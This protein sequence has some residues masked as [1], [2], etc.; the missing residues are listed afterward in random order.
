LN[1]CD[2]SSF[3]QLMATFSL[4][5]VVIKPFQPNS[6]IKFCCDWGKDSVMD[7]IRHYNVMAEVDQEN[8]EL[9]KDIVPKGARAYPNLDEDALKE[10]CDEYSTQMIKF[11]SVS[12]SGLCIFTLLFCLVALVVSPFLVHS[13]MLSVLFFIYSILALLWLVSFRKFCMI[14][15]DGGK[16]WLMSRKRINRKQDFRH[17][18]IPFIH[19]LYLMLLAF[20]LTIILNLGLTDSLIQALASSILTIAL[21]NASWCFIQ[22]MYVAVFRIPR[23]F[24]TM[25]PC[26]MDKRLKKMDERRKYIKEQKDMRKKVL[27]L[28]EVRDEGD[29][30]GEQI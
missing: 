10:E 9:H 22:H 5:S 6:F 27:Q 4:A 19:Q 21:L 26:D 12:F 16:I 20:V 8:I 3:L 1:I 14:I 18:K 2:F 25:I 30:W 17:Y 29:N 11:E 7:R 13:A 15:Q 28:F 23:T 24:L